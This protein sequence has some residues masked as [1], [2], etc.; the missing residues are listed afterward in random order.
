MGEYHDGEVFPKAEVSFEHAVIVANAGH[1]FIGRLKGK[2]CLAATDG[3]VRSTSANAMRPDVMVVFGRP[4]YARES[5]GAITN[6]KVIVEVLSP[7][8]ADY[9]RGGKFVLYQNLSSFEEYLLVAQETPRIDMF[10]KTSANGW[11]L[12]I[13]VGLESVVT[14][15]PL[16][17]E[18]PM[19]EF[20]AGVEFPETPL[21][22]P[23]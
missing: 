21:D 14:I 3:V 18:I 17:I 15:S 12:K 2:P 13:H 16:G 4:V 9:D 8:T 20:Y 1:C 19:A 23:A 5:R 10:R 7:S 6:P 22:S 11:D